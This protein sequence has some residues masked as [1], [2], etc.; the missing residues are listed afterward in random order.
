MIK[1]KDL[2]ENVYVDN[3]QN[4]KL[5]RVGDEWGSKG[6]KETVV[7]TKPYSKEQ[8]YDETDENRS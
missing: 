8:A 3:S 5:N 1:L 7:K 2:L 6:D 4:R